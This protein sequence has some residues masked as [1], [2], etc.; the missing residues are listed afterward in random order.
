MK[1]K[2][3][4]AAFV[5]LLIAVPVMSCDEIG[6]NVTPAEISVVKKELTKDSAGQTV[7]IVTVKNSGR[8]EADFAEVSVKFYD[9]QKNLI[10][11]NRD[12]VLSLHPGETWEFTIP[13]NSD[14]SRVASYEITTTSS[15]GTGGL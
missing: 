2:V 11:S 6:G 7:L 3:I 8:V 14:I 9:S 4:I 1:I 15:A 13:C 12:S 10:D 5:L